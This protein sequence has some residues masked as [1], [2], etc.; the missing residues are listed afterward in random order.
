DFLTKP[1]DIIKFREMVFECLDKIDD[2]RQAQDQG[3]YHGLRHVAD[4]QIIKTLGEGVSGVVFEVE[5]EGRHYALKVFKYTSANENRIPELRERFEREATFLQD[6]DH[7]N[8][9]KVF[10]WGITSDNIPYIVME[11]I[12]GQSLKRIIQEKQP[13][14]IPYVANL[15]KQLAAALQAIHERGAVHRDVKPDNILVCPDNILKITDFGIMRTPDSNLTMASN[16]MGSPA[17]LAPEGFVTARVDHRSDLFSLGVVAYELFT[18][19]RPFLAD[20]IYAVATAIQSEYPPAPSS[21]RPDLSADIE[22][23]LA[24]LL[25]KD[26]EY[27]FASAELLCQAFDNIER[28]KPLSDIPFPPPHPAPDWLQESEE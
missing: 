22:K 24:S 19:R 13:I 17:Y 26:P 20:N 8:I 4:Y 1:F 6:I 12:R 27:R 16:I 10:E 7:P 3:P 11:L 9:I 2:D 21:L 14:P 15:L 18:G 28:G 25:V 5:K 23:L